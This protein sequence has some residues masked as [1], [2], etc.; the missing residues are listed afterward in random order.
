MGD[1]I[2]EKYKPFFLLILLTFLLSSCNGLSSMDDSEGSPVAISEAPV[3]TQ[4]ILSSSSYLKPCDLINLSQMEAIFQESPLFINEENGGCVVRNQWDTRSIW[5]SVFQGKQALTAMQWHTRQLI[6]GWDDEDYQSLVDGIL[7][8]QNNQSLIALQEARLVVYE[9]MEFRWERFLTVGDSAFWILNSRAFKGVLDVVEAQY[10]LQLGFSGFMA[11]Q[12]QPDIENL[13]TAT[14]NK[15]PDQFFVNFNFPDEDER[16]HISEEGIVDVPTILKV[17]KTNQEIYFGDLCGDE[18]TTIRVQIDNPEI[19]DN[20]YLVFRLVS[21][22]E[23]ND[24]WKTEFMHELTP[25]IWEI[26]LSAEK[27]FLTYQLING[28]KVEYNIAVIYGVDSVVRS[29]TFSDILLLQ[30]RK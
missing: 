2:M 26:T 27:S 25:T 28:A 12:I 18:T 8:D 17:T 4:T 11:A 19:V 9:K 15:I 5:I 24:N 1:P 10:Y 14:L 6:D 21:N 23:T 22:T 16:E 3:P 29:S 30:C 7:N 20:V 13:A